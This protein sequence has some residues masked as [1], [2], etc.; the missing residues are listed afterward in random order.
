MS[1]VRA[2]DLQK[3]IETCP[4]GVKAPS[5]ETLNNSGSG[6]DAPFSMT[7]NSFIHAL[8]H[9]LPLYSFTVV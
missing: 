6:C 7:L 8:Y 1:T 5:G 4:C 3:I 2:F 9:L